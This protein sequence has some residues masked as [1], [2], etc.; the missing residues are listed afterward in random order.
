MNCLLFNSWMLHKLIKYVATYIKSD[1]QI[2]DGSLHVWFVQDAT[3]L[4]P[5]LQGN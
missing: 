5:S 4:L 2:I 1:I 3:A